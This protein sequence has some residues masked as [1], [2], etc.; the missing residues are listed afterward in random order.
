METII[1]RVTVHLAF[2]NDV[3]MYG[4]QT[5]RLGKKTHKQFENDVNMYGTQTCINIIKPCLKFENDV[6][7]VVRT[8]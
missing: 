8:G 4:T 6:R 7:L 5:N 3:N 1:R 2:E